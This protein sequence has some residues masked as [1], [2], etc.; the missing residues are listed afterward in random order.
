MKNI[1]VPVDFSEYSDHA[2]ELAGRIARKTGARVALVHILELPIDLVNMEWMAATD[3]EKSS[4]D[5]MKLFPEVQKLT[6]RTEHELGEWKKK[7]WFQDVKVSTH[8]YYNQPFDGIVKHAREEKADL[9]VMGSHGKRGFIRGMM[10]SVTQKVV[11]L[12]ELPILVVKD[13]FPERDI[14]NIVFASDY[15]TEGV[16]AFKRVAA[17]AEMLGADIELVHINTPYNFHGT[18]DMKEKMR[19]YQTACGTSGCSVSI[20]NAMKEEEGILEFC[21]E[22]KADMVAMGTHARSGL[23]HLLLTSITEE[24]L[25]QAELPVLTVHYGR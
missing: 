11:R 5:Q 20:F 16:A 25:D 10:G 13:R 12:S 9:I 8:L 19:A 4:N 2:A 17:F 14:L 21:R 15:S 3:A 23:G 7:P 1:V 18:H 24:V 6:Y 22:I